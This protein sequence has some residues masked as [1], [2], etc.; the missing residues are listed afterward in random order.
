MYVVQVGSGLKGRSHQVPVSLSP[1]ERYSKFEDFLNGL[2]GDYKEALSTE[3]EV[4]AYRMR[5]EP[6]TGQVLDLDH[7]PQAAQNRIR[8]YEGVFIPTVRTPSLLDNEDFLNLAAALGLNT[9]ERLEEELFFVIQNAAW[10]NEIRGDL[11]PGGGTV[12][13]DL[14]EYLAWRDYVLANIGFVPPRARNKSDR[15]R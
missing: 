1:S 10:Q 2:R 13:G 6:G 5:K 14:Y 9:R 4:M 15:V 7:L 12:N 11:P 3:M 8:L